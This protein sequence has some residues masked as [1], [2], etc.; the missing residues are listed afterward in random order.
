METPMPDEVRNVW[1]KLNDEPEHSETV[2][3]PEAA[4]ANAAK[5]MAQAA[6]GT[7]PE[8]RAIAEEELRAL[9]YRQ[10]YLTSA[11]LR[12]IMERDH[13]DVTTHNL[14]AL[15]PLMNWAAGQELVEL[16]NT[17]R[18]PVSITNGHWI[19]VWRSLVWNGAED[20]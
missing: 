12:M 20:D 4:M 5:G 18:S 10:S 3:D 1:G 14:S 9:A 16:V 13:P 15:G 7:N 11:Q 8:W 19:A 6:A 17:V 2:I